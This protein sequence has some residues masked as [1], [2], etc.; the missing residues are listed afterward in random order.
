MGLPTRTNTH[1][2]PRSFLVSFAHPAEGRCLLC[3]AA[4]VAG[5][6]TQQTLSTA[7]HSKQCL[8]CDPAD[9]DWRAAQQ[10]LSVASH[11]TQ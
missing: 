10:A 6:V 9:I 4:D 7:S 2:P 8:P 1:P 5:C 3:D 11:S